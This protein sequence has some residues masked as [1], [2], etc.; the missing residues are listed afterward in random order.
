MGADNLINFHRW[1]NWKKIAK[2]CQITVY[3]RKGYVKKSLNSVAFRTLGKTG[4]LFLKS[5]MFNISSSKIR[6]NYLKYWN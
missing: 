4:V 1:K 6:K 3:P 2:N 5:K